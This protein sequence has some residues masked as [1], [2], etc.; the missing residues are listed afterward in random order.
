MTAPCPTPARILF[1]TTPAD[2]HTVPALPIA[3]ALVE[4]GHRVRWYAGS[5]YADRIRAIGA[6]Y[7]PMSD[8][9]F[10]LI[11]LDEYF[12]A[13][14]ELSGLAK[15]KFD[16]VVGFSEPTRTHLADLSAALEREPA[17]L[18]VGDTGMGAGPMLTELGGPPFAALGISVV[19]FPSDDVPPFGV[20]LGPTTTLLG[21][22]R[23]RL[24]HTLVR[25]TL[26]AGMTR[27]VNQIRIDHGLPT[28]DEIVFEYMLHA[29]LYL[30]LGAKGFEYPQR[31]LPGH[32]RF[33]GPVRP[34]PLDSW[35]EPEWWADLGA[36]T[37]V[38]VLNQGTV[39]TDPAELLQPG[40][41]ALADEDVLV[42]AVTG[43]RDPRDLGAL[44]ANARVERFIPFDRLL[45][46][47]DV[48][49]TN[50]GF[51]AVQLALAAGV[52]IVAAGKT[53]DKIEVAA[54]VGRSGVGIN[55]RTQRPRPDA[56]SAAVRQVLGDNRFRRRAAELQSEIS[57][58]GR[59]HGAVDE[60]E[61]LL[62]QRRKGVQLDPLTEQQPVPR[63]G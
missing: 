62:C 7:V 4:R 11:G 25:R 21:S 14:K 37:P 5:K 30:Q 57:A 59:E 13:R 50:A 12:P 18:V 20:G 22:L 60:L 35:T 27:A 1:A 23:N 49:V 15:L 28:R 47:A 46:L 40:L 61:K 34:E 54:R 24:L 45:P 52:P 26:F 53:E 58:A 8:H 55:L 44:P 32:V 17:D 6:E 42:V 19:G 29:A 31:D 16:M 3:R 48:L 63:V 56:I 51:G 9:D 10:S 39:A 38:V 2:G 36:G 43:G 41:A 33:V